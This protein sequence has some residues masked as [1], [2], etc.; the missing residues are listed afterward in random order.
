MALE[1]ANQVRQ[2]LHQ[3]TLSL[4]WRLG[5]YSMTITITAY[6][7]I[8]ESEFAYS[9]QVIV[10]LKTMGKT[11][12]YLHTFMRKATHVAYATKTN[13]LDA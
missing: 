13:W 4:S 11:S 12:Q 10:R 7:Y 5:A 1:L 9:Y 3:F 8:A 6:S 2:A